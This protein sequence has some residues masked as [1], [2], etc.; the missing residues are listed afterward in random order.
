MGVRRM[1]RNRDQLL[2]NLAFAGSAVAGLLHAS[3]FLLLP[4]LMFLTVLVLEDR[5]VRRR[6]GSGA[7]P[8]VGYAR[9][10]FGTNLYLLLRN[11]VFSTAI[12]AIA[13]TAGSL[14]RG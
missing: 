10:L 13:S 14:L 1:M 7:W 2:T 3:T 6:I 4:P 5:A 11:T 12:F 8:S 9:F